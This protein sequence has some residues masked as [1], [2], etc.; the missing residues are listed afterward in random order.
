MSGKW[1]STSVLYSSVSIICSEQH[2]PSLCC[3]HLAFSPGDSLKWC[4]YTKVLT[5]LQFGRILILFYQRN[6]IFIWSLAYFEVHAL[7]ICMLTS[8]SVNEILLLRYT[9]WFTNFRGLPFNEEMAPSW[10]KYMNSVLSEF[11]LRPMLLAGC[12]SHDTA[13]AGVFARST[14]S[15]V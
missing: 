7:L 1:P 13:W 2:T 5:W 8:S 11:V 14:W 4:N 6:Q 10:L 12:F 15:Y 3:F 9:N